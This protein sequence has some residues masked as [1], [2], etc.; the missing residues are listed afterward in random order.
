MQN[1]RNNLHTNQSLSSQPP[2][3]CCAF[4][5]AD[6]LKALREEDTSIRWYRPN[7]DFVIWKEEGEKKGERGTDKQTER[8]EERTR[9]VKNGFLFVYGPEHEIRW[10]LAH[11]S[12]MNITL[13]LSISKHSAIKI[14]KINSSQCKENWQVRYAGEILFESVQPVRFQC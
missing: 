4:I 3:A 6:A 10:T 8:N 14:K 2:Y 5:S 12:Q 1:K 11:H 9:Q 13:S 7:V